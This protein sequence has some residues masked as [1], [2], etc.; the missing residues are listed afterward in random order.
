MHLRKGIALNTLIYVLSDVIVKA[1]PFFLIPIVTRY[2]TVEEYGNVSLLLTLVEV[3]TIFIIM[4]GHNY[5]RYKY[6]KENSHKDLILVPLILSTLVFVIFQIVSLS[7]FMWFSQ[8][9]FYVFL[10][11]V[12]FFQS[13][14]ALV[15]CKFQMQQQPMKVA[16][17]NVSLAIFSF[18]STAILLHFNFGYAGR[19]NSIILT[20]VVVGFCVALLLLRSAK[21]EWKLVSVEFGRCLSFGVKSVL[22]SVSWWLRGGMDRI[23]IQY[24]LG[25]TMLGLFAVAMQLSLVISVISLAINNSIMPRIFKLV[26]SNE[27]FGLAKLVVI[28]FAVI[29]FSACSFFIVSPFMFKFILPS[30]YLEAQ[31]FLVP[32]LFGVLA[33]SL[34]LVGCN[35]VTAMGR[36]AVLSTVAILGAFIHMLLSFVLAKMYGIDGLLWSSS[37]SYIISSFILLPSLF[38]RNSILEV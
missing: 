4:G 7:L 18:I 24:V 26:N 37:L 36:P 35:I 1:I 22:T 31:G 17:V 20:P 32:I 30:S 6:F 27:Y 21:F 33:H 19:V 34:F 29:L 13:I 16:L 3:S 12:A 23:I 10:P 14:C 38:K 2:L 11:L 25:S 9:S 15:V 28:S 5:Y 8:I